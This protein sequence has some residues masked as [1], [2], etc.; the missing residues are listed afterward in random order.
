MIIES[1]KV[2]FL[3]YKRIGEGAL[4][5]VPDNGFNKSFGEGN[6]SITVIVRHI[7]GNLTSRFTDFLSSDGEKQWRNRDGEFETVELDRAGIIKSWN[8]GWKV[9]LD[10]L[11]T[12][13]DDDMEK[14]VTLYGKELRALGAI[15][16]ALTHLSYHVGQIV[17][18][19]R[20]FAGDNWQTL[21]IAKGKSSEYNK[22]QT[23]V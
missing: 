12:L 17:I 7:S 18:I 20:S 15:H 3:K 8:D 10:T 6:N 1:I 14:T 16:Q 13:T 22:N 2:E 4:K 21:S 11:E 19:A 9:L 23:K 5:Q